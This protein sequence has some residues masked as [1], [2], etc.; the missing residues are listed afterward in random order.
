MGKGSVRAA[1][2]AGG[3]RTAAAAYTA[4]NKA[5][6]SISRSGSALAQ[7][8]GA[9]LTFSNGVETVRSIRDRIVEGQDPGIARA[10]GQITVP[11]ADTALLPQAQNA[12][13]AAFEFAYA[14]DVNRG[15]ALTLHEV[16]LALAKT[17]IEGPGGVEATF[18]FRPAY[19]AAATRMLTI[20]LENQQ[21]AAEYA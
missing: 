19:N 12:A 14:I 3:T 5:Q 1:T 4:F 9:K 16:Y 17:P 18:D 15:L 2:S 8:T 20:A 13:P 10:T 21:A 11:F 6:G 7:V